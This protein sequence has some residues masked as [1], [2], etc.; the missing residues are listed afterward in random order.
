[1]NFKD[2]ALSHQNTICLELERV[3]LLLDK[4]NHPEKSFR[5][6]HVAGTNGKGSVCAFITEGLIHSG[7]S[8]GRFSSPELFDVCDTIAVNNKNIDIKKLESFYEYVAPFCG[9]IETE[10]GK[11]PSQFEINFVCALLFFK[12]SACDYAVVECGM[13]GMADATNAMCDS[14]VSI[15]TKISLDHEAFLGDSKEKIA[16]NKCG[17]FKKSSAVFTMDQTAEVLNVIKEKSAK[18]LLTVSKT[19]QI[20]SHKDFSAVVSFDGKENINLSLCGI[21]Q[22]DNAS[23]ARE[24]LLYLGCGKSVKYALENAKNPARF[25]KL[26]DNVFFDGAH[27]PDGVEKLVET[28]NLF[29]SEQKKIIFVIGFMAD[30]DYKKA[31]QSLKRLKFAGFEIYTVK[32]HSNPRSESSKKLCEVCRALGYSTQEKDNISDACFD[33]KRNADTVFAF[34]SLYMYKEYKGL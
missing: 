5:V 10:T 11:T 12:E 18:K 27:N 32:V 34:G 17:I 25:E 14:Y 16:E 28:L 29:G 21:H 33:A 4:C 23:L 7:Y 15:I 30:K 26:E 20:V 8:V 1:M 3:S 31:L 19:P 6:I 22:A 13:G 9:E 2:Y 24:V